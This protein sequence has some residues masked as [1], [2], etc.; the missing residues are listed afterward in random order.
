MKEETELY[1]MLECNPWDSDI[2]FE[3]K[4]DTV[5]QKYC[6]DNKKIKELEEVYRELKKNRDNKVKPG[7]TEGEERCLNNIYDA[8][9]QI[10]K[11]LENGCKKIDCMDMIN[12][13]EL[14]IYLMED[15]WVHS[16]VKHLKNNN[17]EKYCSEANYDFICE[18]YF[19]N[20]KNRILGSREDAVF[21]WLKNYS[22]S[23]GNFIHYARK[24]M[25]CM[26]SD[27]KS[28][29]IKRSQFII[30]NGQN[31]KISNAISADDAKQ[32]TQIT[33][34]DKKNFEKYNIAEIIKILAIG[35]K[36]IMISQAGNAKSQANE[37]ARYYI[38]NAVMTF[39][40]AFKISGITPQLIDNI[41]EKEMS[42]ITNPANTY[43]I[44]ETMSK[45]FTNYIKVDECA[46]FDD[47]IDVEL[48]NYSDLNINHNG[49][50]RLFKNGIKYI[51]EIL[52]M[53]YAVVKGD[54]S[55]KSES[56]K[57]VRTRYWNKLKELIN[58]YEED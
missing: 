54:N 51:D 28:E 14:N 21:G 34:G 18:F 15:Y 48:C 13:I 25:K 3:K 35:P 58:R 40:E 43:D 44:F 17:F 1:N 26:R 52:V 27:L 19:E 56:I 29:L 2:E 37:Y 20:L 30:N 36:L 10:R 41:L 39:L 33:K 16:T 45:D 53:Y 8:L 7:D 22:D 31:G 4:Y 6:Q 47:V 11:E 42:D 12:K 38:V 46:N 55:K 24:S 50:I 5:R 9:L 57:T 49:Q 23:K 32:D